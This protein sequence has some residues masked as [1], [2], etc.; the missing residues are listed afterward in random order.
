MSEKINEQIEGVL[1]E[2]ASEIRQLTGRPVKLSYYFVT[3]YSSEKLKEAIKVITGVDEKDLFEST[4]K[5]PVCRARQ[6]YFYFMAQ[7]YSSG[8]HGILSR[9]FNVH[10][11]TVIH[12]IR[13]IDDLLYVKDYETVDWVQRISEQMQL[14]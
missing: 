10:H 8:G 1:N 7:N 4:R 11:T 6:I 9:Q 13:K 12:S 5:N 14:S 3:Q 2:A